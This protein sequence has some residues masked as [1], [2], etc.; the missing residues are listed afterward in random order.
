[1]VAR[2][3]NVECDEPMTAD[4]PLDQI[5]ISA[6]TVTAEAPDARFRVLPSGLLAFRLPDSKVG[7]PV[8]LDVVRRLKVCEHG[9]QGGLKESSQGHGQDFCHRAQAR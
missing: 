7:K 1:M 2:G 9:P 6:P 5:E 8:W 4:E 3:P